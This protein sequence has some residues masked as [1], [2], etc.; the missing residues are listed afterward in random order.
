M[1]IWIVY[2]TLAEWWFVI[3]LL[4]SSQTWNKMKCYWGTRIFCGTY[5]FEDVLMYDLPFVY[6]IGSG[7][8]WAH[9][10]I[11]LK[12]HWPFRRKTMF[13]TVRL[14]NGMYIYM[15][16]YIYNFMKHHSIL[17]VINIPRHIFI[18]NMSIKRKI[19]FYITSF[20]YSLFHFKF[21]TVV[22]SCIFIYLLKFYF[23]FV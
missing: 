15:Y 13:C 14:E 5:S 23:S 20:T 6:G 22:E 9:N 4:F 2:I 12:V 19:Y 17:F 10:I 21:C 18:D 7:V 8:Q 11:F 1:F 3:L 16:I